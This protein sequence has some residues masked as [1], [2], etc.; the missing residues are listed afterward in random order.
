MLGLLLSL[1]GG[2]IVI[3]GAS[4][5]IL[6][7]VGMYQGALEHPLDDPKG[8]EQSVSRDMLAG[9]KIGAIGVVPLLAG[10]ILTNVGPFQRLAA[11]R[12]TPPPRP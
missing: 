10:S 1:L 3:Y 7:L 5:A 8:G 2:G 12:T 11:K 4:L 6:A 9:V